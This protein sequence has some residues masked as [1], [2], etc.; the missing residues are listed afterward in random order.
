[1]S[2]ALLSK[3]SSPSLCRDVNSC[4]PV[5]VACGEA[6]GMAGG[7]GNKCI[8]VCSFD[9]RGRE[10]QYLRLFAGRCPTRKNSVSFQ[11][12]KL[13][14]GGQATMRWAQQACSDLLRA[15]A[16]AQAGMWGILLGWGSSAGV[17]TSHYC[18]HSFFPLFS[19]CIWIGDCNVAGM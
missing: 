19:Y 18:S 5:T 4:Y 7:K 14:K 15:P 10:S 3:R 17:Q 1:M 2:L 6:G 12:R 11:S 16:P 9:D 13:R 8:H